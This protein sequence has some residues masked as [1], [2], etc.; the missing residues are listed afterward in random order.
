MVTIVYFPLMISEPLDPDSHVEDMYCLPAKCGLR[1][2]R[3][4]LVRRQCFAPLHRSAQILKHSFSSMNAS[5]FLEVMPTLLR[6]M[7]QSLMWWQWTK[8]ESASSSHSCLLFRSD[9]V[10]AYNCRNLSRYLCARSSCSI[11][12]LSAGPMF[13]FRSIALM[14]V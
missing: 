2:E 4:V 1:P 3:D 13:D 12:S 9:C 7:I 5:M 8:K 11:L 10:P 14:V 6:W